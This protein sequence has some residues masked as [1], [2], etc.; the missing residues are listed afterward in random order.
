V[1]TGIELFVGQTH[2]MN[3]QLQVGTAKENVQVLGQAQ[4]VDSSNA[5]IAGVVQSKQ[6]ED[7]PLN[8]RNWSTLALLTP[9]AV[10][11][12]GG[13]QRDIRFVGRGTDDNNYTFDGLDATGVQEQNQK[14]AV[15]LPISLGSIGEFRVASS[16]YTADKGG[17]AGA[18][19]SVV[20]KAGTNA[21]HGAAFDFL[22]DNVFDARGPF[23]IDPLTNLGFIPPLRLNQFGGSIGGPI[24]KDRTF[25]YANYEGL[26][27]V[28][29]R[30]VIGFVPSRVPG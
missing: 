27:Q 7:I 17:S 6:V 11:L 24:Q 3:A 14:A 22:R 10:N 26:R 28:Q 23:D 2:T 18:Q 4:A 8:G 13:G 30:T 16:Q 19:I 25:F 29:D 1:R 20:T 21:F 15:R 9:G 5:E 12:G